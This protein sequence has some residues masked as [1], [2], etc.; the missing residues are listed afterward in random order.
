MWSATM[1]LISSGIVRSKLRSPDSRWA[2]SMPR[3]DAQMAAATVEFT[4]P[5]TITRSGRSAARMGSSRSMTRAVCS[6]WL[7]DPT[8]S[9]WSGS[10]TPSSS[11]KTWDI[12]LS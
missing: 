5:G 7:P 3:R 1:R 10:G 6:A 8:P 9:M 4:S 2:T 12:A 11:K